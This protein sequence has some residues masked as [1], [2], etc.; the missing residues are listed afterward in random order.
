[1]DKPPAGPHTKR[2]VPRTTNQQPRTKSQE[3]RTKNQR[4]VAWGEFPTLRA[5]AP[6]FPLSSL[7]LYQLPYVSA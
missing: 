1:M 6:P 5:A 3:A 2:R 4:T 7:F